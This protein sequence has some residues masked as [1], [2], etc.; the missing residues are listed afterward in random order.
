MTTRI[1]VRVDELVLH[2]IAPGDRHPIADALERELGRLFAVTALSARLLEGGD[3]ARLDAGA[4]PMT[5]GAPA[6][7]LGARVAQTVFGGLN[8]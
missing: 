1:E 6:G 5:A 3:V 8:G 7:T 4:V 2:G